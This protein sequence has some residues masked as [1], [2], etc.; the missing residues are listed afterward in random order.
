MDGEHHPKIL[1]LRH[2]IEVH[3][4]AVVAVP[5]ALPIYECS[6]THDREWSARHFMTSFPGSGQLMIFD[7]FLKHLGD[8][9]NPKKHSNHCFV[10]QGFRNYSTTFPRVMEIQPSKSGDPQKN[11]PPKMPEVSAVV[12]LVESLWNHQ[13]M[14]GACHHVKSTSM[15]FEYPWCLVKNQKTTDP[16]KLV[17]FSPQ[18]FQI[19]DRKKHLPEKSSKYSVHEAAGASA[20]RAAASSPRSC[21]LPRCPSEPTSFVG[22]SLAVGWRC[23]ETHGNPI[24]N[25]RDSCEKT[26][27]DRIS[28][29]FFVFFFVMSCHVVFCWKYPRALSLNPYV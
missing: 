14:L 12:R 21:G 18:H 8:R 2:Y 29:A 15:A 1:A 13:K 27:I 11:D 10:F 19:S 28:T 17:F 5:S 16:K 20:A 25:P 6:K 9:I 23:R 3:N 24:G 22:R 26:M 7:D 4:N